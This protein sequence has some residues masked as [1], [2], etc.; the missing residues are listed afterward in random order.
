MTWWTEPLRRWT[1]ALEIDVVVEHAPTSDPGIIGAWSEQPNEWWFQLDESTRVRFPD[2]KPTRAMREAL[3]YTL[4]GGRD[5]AR[6]TVD[7]MEQAYRA[8]LE[9]DV[10]GLV[11]ASTASAPPCIPASEYWSYPGYLFL[12]RRKG[13]VRTDAEEVNLSWTQ[14]ISDMLSAILG[15]GW[16]RELGERKDV[17]AY[18]PVSKLEEAV[19]DLPEADDDLP[20][21]DRLNSVAKLLVSAIAED[22]YFDVRVSVSRRIDKPSQIHAG[23][24]SA[25]LATRL[26]SLANTRTS[27]FGEGLL[28]LFATLASDEA[29]DAFWQV[30]LERAQ[31]PVDAWPEDWLDIVQGVIQAN[32]NISEAARI[33]Y[34][35]RNT[36]IHKLDRLAQVTGYDVRNITDAMVLYVAAL[37]KTQQVALK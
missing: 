18:L 10:H 36:L 25:L 27:V 2:W 22:A 7:R 30:L 12:V 28:P 21:I 32:L 20:I 3:G 23:L 13:E 1:D 15:E 8:L 37:L 4:T 16:H 6:P 35:H 26:Q 24:A 14:V 11:R 17:V 34:V 9:L 5:L 19:L 33:L 31:L 29:V